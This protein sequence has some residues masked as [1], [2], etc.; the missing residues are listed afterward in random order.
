MQDY[1][2][3]AHAGV[4]A[5]SRFMVRDGNWAALSLE[6]KKKVIDT[7]EAEQEAARLEALV[8]HEYVML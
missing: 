8:S 5:V 6:E 2:A 3:A 4:V 1:R 7:W